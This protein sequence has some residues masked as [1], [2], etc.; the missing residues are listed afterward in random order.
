MTSPTRKDAVFAAAALDC[1]TKSRAWEI[2]R[3]LGDGPPVA[4]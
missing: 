4:E 3:D 2:L 1:S